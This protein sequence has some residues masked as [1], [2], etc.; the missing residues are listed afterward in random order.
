MDI[1]QEIDLIFQQ[2]TH[3]S[4]AVERVYKLFIPDF[5]N[6]QIIKGH[7]TAGYSLSRY[8]WSKFIEFDH[9]H[10]PDVMAGGEWLNYGFSESKN[11]KDWQVDLST[12]QI[13]K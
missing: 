11:L 3:Q 4:Q 1:K 9:T 2:A 12:C 6:I 10:H 13:I 7:P 8:L 5:D